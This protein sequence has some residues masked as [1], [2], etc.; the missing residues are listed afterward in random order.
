MVNYFA[1]YTIVNFRLREFFFEYHYSILAPIINNLI[2]IIVFST[3]DKFYN[4]TLNEISFIE[5]LVPG[6]IMMIV[7]QE[8]FDNTSVSIINCKQVGSFD[9]FLY[10]PISRFELFLSYIF[11]QILIGLFIGIIN[12]IIL[13]FF[14]DFHFFSFFLFIYYLILV[15]LFFSSIGLI[16]GFLSYTWDS[17]S[18]VSNFFVVP[19]NFLSGTFF[20]INS[21]PE[22]FK[23]FLMY[24]PYYHIITFFRDSFYGYYKFDFLINTFLF[25]FVVSIFLFGA[26]I[27]CKGYKVIK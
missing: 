6:L 16:V 3:I 7:A 4:F 11:S 23:F 26:F 14:I 21:L 5:F 8:S 2:F 10:A 24:N 15:I 25:I 22:N 13:S 18:T 12:L 17:Q 9:D 1:I 19:I 27:F 20:S